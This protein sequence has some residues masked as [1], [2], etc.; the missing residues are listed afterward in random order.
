MN[1]TSQEMFELLGDENKDILLCSF[2]KKNVEIAKEYIEYIKQNS[3]PEY[4]VKSFNRLCTT[5]TINPDNFNKVISLVSQEVKNALLKSESRH[6]LSEKSIEYFQKK[7]GIDF[8]LEIAPKLKNNN[9]LKKFIASTQTNFLSRQHYYA[10]KD[11]QY[12]TLK[13]VLVSESTNTFMLNM[14]STLDFI[15]KSNYA[16]SLFNEFKEKDLF[17]PLF[18][19]QYESIENFLFSLIKNPFVS[20]DEFEKMVKEIKLKYH[21]ELDEQRTDGKHIYVSF[22]QKNMPTN[23]QELEKLTILYKQV[24]IASSIDELYNLIEEK[25]DL[26]PNLLK[27]LKITGQH[28]TYTTTEMF[29]YLYEMLESKL[30]EKENIHA[31]FDLIDFAKHTAKDNEQESNIYNRF[32]NQFKVDMKKGIKR[33]DYEEEDFKRYLINF[34]SQML[35]KIIEE[36]PHQNTHKLKI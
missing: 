2:T 21:D 35:N 26:I 4:L 9:M 36:K 15:S 6:I 31:L 17:L 10:I 32:L 25:V 20:N 14:E 34:E 24:N 18:K 23:P 8:F 28:N 33:Q 19:D 22:N 29:D 13:N 16:M 5:D 27:V 11:E 12:N 3:T 30:F 7:E 1:L